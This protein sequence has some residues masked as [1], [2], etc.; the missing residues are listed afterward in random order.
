M[1]THHRPSIIHRASRDQTR[2]QSGSTQRTRRPSVSVQPQRAA[3][4]RHRHVDPM[5]S[6]LITENLEQ[7]RPPSNACEQSCVSTR[8]THSTA[9]PRSVPL[10]ALSSQRT[11]AGRRS[12]DHCVYGR[13][14]LRV[15]GE[16]QADR[17]IVHHP[18]AESK[19]SRGASD[20]GKKKSDVH[21]ARPH[22]PAP[23]QASSLSAPLTSFTLNFQ[24]P[25]SGFD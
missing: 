14:L 19:Q 4:A 10:D 20:R 6:S 16:I 15:R 23:V 11:R 25:G 7:L 3:A 17:R 2:D 12:A 18:A 9:G 21:A 1:S 13:A 22:P 24:Q 5:R 8:Q